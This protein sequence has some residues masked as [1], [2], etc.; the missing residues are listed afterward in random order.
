MNLGEVTKIFLDEQAGCKDEILTT[1]NTN[2]SNTFT[3][4]FWV[5]TVKKH[6]HTLYY[7]FTAFICLQNMLVLESLDLQSLMYL[8]RQYIRMSQKVF[9]GHTKEYS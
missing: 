4:N 5:E 8:F 9:V 2:S 7:L 6:T 3:I 1:K